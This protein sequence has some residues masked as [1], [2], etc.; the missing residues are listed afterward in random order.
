[1]YLSNSSGLFCFT[2]MGKETRQCLKLIKK[3][4][5]VLHAN[6]PS[7][8]F[9]GFYIVGCLFTSPAVLSSTSVSMLGGTFSVA[10]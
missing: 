1:M 6:F 10:V 2:D 7:T 4:N 9:F 5:L 8:C 3:K